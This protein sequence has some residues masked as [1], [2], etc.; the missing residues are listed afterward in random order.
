MKTT[1]RSFIGGAAVAS[2]PVAAGTCVAVSAIQV[3]AIAP[4]VIAENPD[5]LAA[6]A[7]MQDAQAE[8][9]DAKDALEWIA[10]EWRHLWPLAP[11]ELLGSA[12][13]D[14]NMGHAEG[15]TNIIGKFI[16]R[17]CASLTK[18]LSPKF[19]HI[20]RRDCFSVITADE[21]KRWLDDF[22]QR[23]P[24]G[25]TPVALEKS[26]EV[27]ERNV[28]KYRERVHLAQVY[29]AETTRLREV[30]GVDDAKKRIAN[31]TRD[32]EA[33]CDEISRL[34]AFGLEGLTIKAEAIAASGLFEA[35]RRD[36]GVL[37]EIGRLV[38]SLI[39]MGGRKPA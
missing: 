5:L 21:G 29:E 24:E 28:H 37:P 27:I 19:R 6:H 12:G 25:R 17:D 8:L 7:R 11:E 22:Q 16:Y 36:D 33:I 23:K 30:A 34:P 20:D 26:R 14:R 35:L 18:R 3:E 9:R 38:Q 1:R 31:A 2:L 15:E 32:V 13:A 39:E 10:D 4:A